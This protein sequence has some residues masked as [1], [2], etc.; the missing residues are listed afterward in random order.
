[1][2]PR[3]VPVIISFAVVVVLLSG[4]ASL[5]WRTPVATGSVLLQSPGCACRF[6][7]PASWFYEAANGDASKSNLAVHSYNDSSA[8][9]VPIP[10]HFADIGIDWLPDP[11]G[12][13]YLAATTRHF[14]PMPG[15]QAKHLVVSNRP[16][17]SFSYWTARPSGGGIFEEHV[18][19]WVPEYQRDYDISLLAANPPSDDVAHDRAVF[20]KLVHSLVIGPQALSSPSPVP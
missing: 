9:H 16:A 10:T 7:Y 5:P 8:A 4:C 17:M 20:A 18:Y 19:V 13:L 15:E 6:V 14:S 12:Q 1:M 3:W 11:T 2:R